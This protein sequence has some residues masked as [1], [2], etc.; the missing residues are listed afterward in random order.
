MT[1]FGLRHSRSKAKWNKAAP[2]LSK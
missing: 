1:G 2:L